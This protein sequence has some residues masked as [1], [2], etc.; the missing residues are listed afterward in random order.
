MCSD[1]LYLPVINLVIFVVSEI[2]VVVRA[3]TLRGI[4]GHL[5]VESGGV[6]LDLLTKGSPGELA[7]VHVGGV[8]FH[9]SVYDFNQVGMC[10]YVQ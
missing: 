2:V 7:E 5:L 10:S 9:E 3:R 1:V 6:P 4:P 8:G